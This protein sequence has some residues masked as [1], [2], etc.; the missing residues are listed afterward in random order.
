MFAS[1]KTTPESVTFWLREEGFVV[2][3]LNTRGGKKQLEKKEL[4]LLSF[5]QVI[6]R[7]LIHW[8]S[9]YDND[10]EYT[11]FFAEELKYSSTLSNILPS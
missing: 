5:Q 10:V 1:I 6:H 8:H 9:H 11:V 4:E 7:I 3:G 2:T